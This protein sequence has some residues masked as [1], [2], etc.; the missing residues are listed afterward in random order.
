MCASGGV[1]GAQNEYRA[2][3][4]FDF[5]VDVFFLFDIVLNFRT[6]YYFESLLVASP[7]AIARHYLRTWFPVDFLSSVPLDWFVDGG[8]AV[9]TDLGS[10]GAAGSP[11]TQFTTLL[12]VFKVLKLLKLLRIARLLR[13]FAR[14]EEH[15]AMFNS[16]TL[17]LF[18]VVVMLMIFAHW[19]A[20][21]Q[22][23]LGTF[24]TT[25]DANDT[26]GCAV[27]THCG[28]IHRDV[29]MCRADIMDLHSMEKWSWSFFVTPRPTRMEAMQGEVVL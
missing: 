21:S 7:S 25:T 13:Y 29:W 4:A 6:A 16:H 2:P 26:C 1:A 27:S 19:N 10:G 28:A 23:Y 15:L 18:K 5:L 14:W 24:D 20:C 17:R 11:A 3:A 9:F 22:F 12:R 8:P